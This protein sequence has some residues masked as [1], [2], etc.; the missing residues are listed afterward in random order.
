VLVKVPLACALARRCWTRLQ[1][2]WLMGENGIAQLL[3]PAHLLVHH[4]E[5]F[6]HA[7]H[8]LDAVI[9]GLAGQGA[10]QPRRR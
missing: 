8:I 1:D 6:G 9:P 10:V 3:G 7:G 2:L 4:V 5:D